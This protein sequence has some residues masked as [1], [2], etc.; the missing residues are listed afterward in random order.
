VPMSSGFHGQPVMGGTYPALIFKSF[1]QAAFAYLEK[2][3][4]AGGWQPQS[5]P[6]PS[7]APTETKVLA[8]RNGQALLDNGNCRSTFPVV[9]FSGDGPQGIAHC[10]KNEVEVPRV[11][12]QTVPEAT[13]R[14]LQQP[15]KAQVVYRP[16]KPLERPNVVV[17]Q[18]PRKGVMS[19][20]QTVTLVLAK[21]VNGLVPSVVGLTPARARLRLER[22]HMRLRIAS[23]AG[24]KPG[25]ILHQSLP[26]GCAAAPQ[27]TLSVVVGR[28]TKTPAPR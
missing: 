28:S 6:V 26:I 13:A 16:A 5:F 12:G 2:T 14:L 15:L 4:P 21:P 18:I 25:T 9:Y 27:L 11:I 19:S 24:G 20:W 22:V 7:Y 10:L 3:D 1:M 23:F 17:D 8:Y